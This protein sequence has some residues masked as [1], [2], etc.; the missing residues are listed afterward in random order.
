[1]N[2]G[3]Y[4]PG[5]ATTAVDVINLRRQGNQ[6]IADLLA[7]YRAFV[8]AEEAAIQAA[9][10]PELDALLGKLTALTAESEGRRQDKLARYL[11]LRDAVRE[12]VETV[13]RAYRERSD[14]ERA[15]RLAALPH[16][17]TCGSHRLTPAGCLA[18]MYPPAT[19]RQPQRPR[20][21][22]QS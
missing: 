9:V 22:V 4:A 18:C 19:P 10:A 2:S 1:V 12:H 13:A 16:C 14:A 20:A 11:R 15:T 6:L 5:E 8:A 21:R 17:E 3:D 7:E